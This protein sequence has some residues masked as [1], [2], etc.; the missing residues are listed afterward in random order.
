MNLGSWAFHLQNS[1][2]VGTHCKYNIFH[3]SMRSKILLHFCQ[4]CIKGIKGIFLPNIIDQYHTLCVLVKLITNLQ[5]N[6]CMTCR[7]CDFI[8]VYLAVINLAKCVLVCIHTGL[9]KAFNKI[10]ITWLK[11]K[12][13]SNRRTCNGSNSLL[14]CPSSPP[15][16][17]LR[18]NQ[19][20]IVISRP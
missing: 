15:V 14:P 3:V 20:L 13:Y 12:V 17:L 16:L 5:K 18:G 10:K 4:P 8:K 19:S 2:L 11:K 6:R 7:Y 9:W 1:Y